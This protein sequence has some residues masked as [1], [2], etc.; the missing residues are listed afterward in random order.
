L[1]LTGDW[2]KDIFEPTAVVKIKAKDIQPGDL[3]KIGREV[4][5]YIKNIEIWSDTVPEYLDYYPDVE[6][7]G[8]PLTFQRGS[9]PINYEYLKYNIQK[10]S[11]PI[12]LNE[13]GKIMLSPA[14]YNTYKKIG[15]VSSPSVDEY[16]KNNYHYP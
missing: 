4:L 3:V 6:S 5:T 14:Y 16:D 12:F 2:E 7:Y 11:W 9:Y 13:K 10:I 15:Y 8:L 1:Y